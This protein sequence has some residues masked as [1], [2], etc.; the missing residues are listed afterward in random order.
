V[1]WYIIAEMSDVGY[2]FHMSNSDGLF[3]R[4]KRSFHASAGEVVFGMEDGAVS[5]FGLV[6]GVA[7]TTDQSSTVLIAGVTGAIAAAVSMM[8]G[9]YL[10]IES[11]RDQVK[12]QT[13]EVAQAVR[14]DPAAAAQRVVDRLTATGMDA[15]AVQNVLSA[16]RTQPEALT[17]MAT[18]LVIA[19]PGD[20]AQGP[21]THASWMFV[22]DLLASL[23][24][25]LPFV[26]LPIGPA[27][28]ASV[29]VT[30][31]MMTVLGFGRA[32]LGKRPTGRTVLETVG[33]A[34]A[35]GIA[36]VIAGQAID[37]WFGA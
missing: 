25:V 7:A 31:L 9:S 36:G 30:G 27:R 29:I 35:A 10:D 1:P 22:A 26:F 37:R 13:E 2:H 23:V 34:A 24:P 8:A 6:F 18:A 28:I 32:R 15:A 14:T 16:I 11:Q 5:I 12:V 21:F 33:I 3:A 20:D 17:S 4:I 19:D